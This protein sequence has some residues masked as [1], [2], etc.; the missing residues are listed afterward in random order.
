MLQKVISGLECCT[1][2]GNCGT[3]PWY[4]KDDAEEG[5]IR[6]LMKATLELLKAQVI[7]HDPA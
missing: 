6:T 2:P 3:C 5:C 7:D 1:V 4:P